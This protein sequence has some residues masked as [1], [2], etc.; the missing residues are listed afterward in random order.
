VLPS[1]I[2][3]LVSHVSPFSAKAE[4]HYNICAHIITIILPAFEYYFY[5]I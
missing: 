4:E 2:H 1:Q 3:P 5:Y